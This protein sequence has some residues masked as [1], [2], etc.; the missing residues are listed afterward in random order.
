MLFAG[1]DSEVAARELARRERRASLLDDVLEDYGSLHR[2]LG[3]SDA[4]RLDEH[5]QRI[6]DVERQLRA[7]LRDCGSATA[8]PEFD[9]NISESRYLPELEARWFHL[10]ELA[11]ACDATRVCDNDVSDPNTSR[12]ND[13]GNGRVSHHNMS[14]SQQFY[15]ENLLE[16]MR[17]QVGQLTNIAGRLQD[18]SEGTS[19]VLDSSFC[20]H[21]SAGM[22]THTSRRLPSLGI[23]SLGGKLKQ[24]VSLRYDEVALSEYWLTIMRA[25]GCTDE[26]F[27]DPTYCREPIAAMFA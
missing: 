1:S 27:G 21:M 26:T 22:H 8:L 4:R 2:R 25:Y 23:G 13:S 14:H 5:M 3:T 7:P 10:I 17:W 20:L 11:F 18:I 9:Y 24:G 15:R 12:C 19:T 6:R 16:A